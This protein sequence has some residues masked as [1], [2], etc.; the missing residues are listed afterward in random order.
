MFS[1]RNSAIPAPLLLSTILPE[2]CPAHRFIQGLQQ[3]QV[4]A[5]SQLCPLRFFPSSLSRPAVLTAMSNSPETNLGQTD[6][7]SQAVQANP[8]TNNP[9]IQEIEDWHEEELVQWIQKVKPKLLIDKILEKFKEAYITGNVFLNHAGDEKF[10]ED[11][12]KLPPGTSEN[13]ALLAEVLRRK[14]K[15]HLLYHRYYTQLTHRF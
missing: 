7:S 14:S 8:A 9:T 2:T 5:D 15:S 4:S 3:A 11:R 13:L 10:F 6:V 1:L 12:C